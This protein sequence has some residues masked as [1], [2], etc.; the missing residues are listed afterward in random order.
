MTLY[1]MKVMEK[2]ECAVKCLNRR[3][4]RITFTRVRLVI[5]TDYELEI[6]MRPKAES[7]IAS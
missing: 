1:K 3:N 5:V 7:T 4:M 6:S 2:L